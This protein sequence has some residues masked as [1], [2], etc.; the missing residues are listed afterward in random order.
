M[1]ATPL[2]APLPR[3]ETTARPWG[4][5]NLGTGIVCATGHV[6]DAL[7]LSV[8]VALDGAREFPFQCKDIIDGHAGQI[9]NL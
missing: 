4:R 9:S 5:V 8:D 7:T 1:A 2:P 6:V 3:C